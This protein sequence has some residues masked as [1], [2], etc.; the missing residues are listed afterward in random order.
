MQGSRARPPVTFPWTLR[1]WRKPS[2]LVGTLSDRTDSSVAKRDRPY[3][4]R[5]DVDDDGTTAWR[6]AHVVRWPVRPGR[7]VDQRERVF[8]SK[9]RNSVC[10]I[11]SFDRFVSQ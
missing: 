8:E 7:R 5:T 11:D 2:Y 10:K 3:R 1:H 9:A 6:Q 4:A